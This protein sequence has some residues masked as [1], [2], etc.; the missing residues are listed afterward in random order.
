[1]M[2]EEM[3]GFHAPSLS[4]IEQLNTAVSACAVYCGGLSLFV[5][6]L[7]PGP[8]AITEAKQFQTFCNT[9]IF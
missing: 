4:C 3:Y 8:A 1:M 7:L 2:V 9:L 5:S 6:L